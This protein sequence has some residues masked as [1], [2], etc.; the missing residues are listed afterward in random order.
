M[1]EMR[2]GKEER[3]GERERGDSLFPESDS[4]LGPVKDSFPNYVLLLSR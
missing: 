3:K 1:R 2:T 4:N